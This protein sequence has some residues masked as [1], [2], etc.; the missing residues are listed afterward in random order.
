MVLSSRN[1]K[2]LSSKWAKN[3]A[4]ALWD[5]TRFTADELTRLEIGDSEGYGKGFDGA[6]HVRVQPTDPATATT[7][8]LDIRKRPECGD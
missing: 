3:R 8:K 5:R 6:M 1:S 4:K 7:R 2:Y